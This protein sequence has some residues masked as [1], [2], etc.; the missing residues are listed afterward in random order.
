MTASRMAYSVGVTE[1]LRCVSNPE[2]TPQ[3]SKTVAEGLLASLAA[4]GMLHFLSE[5]VERKSAESF[6]VTGWL[7]HHAGS[8]R[9]TLS[10]R[11]TM[12]LQGYLSKLY[13]PGEGEEDTL[14]PSERS[15]VECERCFGIVTCVSSLFL[16]VV[17]ARAHRYFRD[18]P[19]RLR[20]VL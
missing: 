5:N 19:V 15:Y 7:K 14:L 6:D 4:K 17:Y 10:T 16:L 20:I 1:A 12:E 11:S 2:V 3:I 18:G 9:L 13:S 8:N